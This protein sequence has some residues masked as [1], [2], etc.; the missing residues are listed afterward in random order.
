VKRLFIILL[1][2]GTLT[3]VLLGRSRFSRPAEGLF[4]PP[5]P[6]YEREA[7][8][9]LWQFGTNAFPYLLGWLRYARPAWKEALYRTANPILRGLNPGLQLNDDRQNHLQYGAL[10]VVRLMAPTSVGMVA[11][12]NRLIDGPNTDMVK[13]FAV[14]ALASAGPSGVESLM[15]VLRTPNSRWQASAAAE[16]GN[17]GTNALAAIPIL[18]QCLDGDTLLA[19]HAAGALGRLRLEA[20]IVVPALT[21]SLRDRRDLVRLSAVAALG[22]FRAE[23]RPA[24]PELLRLRDD[25]WLAVRTGATNSIRMIEA[26]S[27]N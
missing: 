6:G 17:V 8:Q 26:G 14:A 27:V 1:A 15:A 5:T 4:Q 19:S 24:V 13:M 20:A 16:I 23:A 3:L 21:H 7:E 9:A 12:L 25:P 10:C 18:I 11:D 22:Q 2:V